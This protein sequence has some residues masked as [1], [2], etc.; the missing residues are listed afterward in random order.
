MSAF[1]LSLPST[2]EAVG[3][4]LKSTL[5]LS[6]MT[7]EEDDEETG[8]RP[9]SSDLLRTMKKMFLVRVLCTVK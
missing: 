5:N 2:S 1:Y 8:E 6:A 4:V 3:T 9:V 7:F